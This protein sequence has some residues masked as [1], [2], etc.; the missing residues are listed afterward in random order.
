MESMRDYLNYGRTD[1]KHG[2]KGEEVERMLIHSP[3]IHR[4]DELNEVIKK[5]I[6]SPTGFCLEQVELG[7]YYGASYLKTENLRK[8]LIE[9]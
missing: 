2:F 6:N 7:L 1:K 3:E 8:A 4:M 9:M 5:A